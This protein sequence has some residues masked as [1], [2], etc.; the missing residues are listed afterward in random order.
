MSERIHPP[1][2]RK[3]Q[4]AKEQGRGPKAEALQS[5]LTLLGGCLL[6]AWFG[7]SFGDGLRQIIGDGIVAASP[8]SSSLAVFWESRHLAAKVV[9]ILAPLPAGLFLLAIVI[10]GLPNRFQMRLTKFAP[11]IRKLSPT[12]RIGE[13]L[14]AKTLA[15]F[16]IRVL[17]VFAMLAV[18]GMLVRNSLVEILLLPGLPLPAVGASVFELL[19]RC[20]CWVGGVMLLFAFA[21]FALSWWHHEQSLRMTEQELRDEMRDMQRA[22][23]AGGNA[24]AKSV[25]G[26]SG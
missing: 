22:A 9:V 26:I 17:Q 8:R 11:S 6:M 13:M 19:I 10:R 14:A 15:D 23:P 16:A 25:E 20:G 1:T 4:Q 7:P 24:R 3:R 18:A 21:D 5:S 12:A 2:P